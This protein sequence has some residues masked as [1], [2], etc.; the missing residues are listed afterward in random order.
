M[1]LKHLVNIASAVLV[2]LGGMAIVI[3]FPGQLEMPYRIAIAVVVILYSV[4]RM[5]QTVMA[6]RRYRRHE[7]G[8]VTGLIER[9]ED[10]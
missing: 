1:Q 10:K 4:L 3:Y 2:L 5:A 8:D 6:I 7:H 9:V